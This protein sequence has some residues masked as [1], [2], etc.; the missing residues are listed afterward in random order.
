[1]G[2]ALDWSALP[3]VCELLGVADPARL[4]HALNTMR[5]HKPE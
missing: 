2:G 4:I 5:R 3:L 1:M